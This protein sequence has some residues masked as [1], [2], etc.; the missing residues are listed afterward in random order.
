MTPLTFLQSHPFTV[1]VNGDDVHIYCKVKGGVTSVMYKRLIQ[2]PQNIK[3]CLEGPYG[4]KYPYDK[5]DSALLFA[6]GNGIPGLY[7]SAMDISK[8]EKTNV[9]LYWIIR[10]WKSIN[11]FLEELQRLKGMKVKVVI[12]VSSPESLLEEVTV[13]TSS[14]EDL[15]EKKDSSAANVKD[16]LS[17]VE[18]REGRPDVFKVL[19]QD[20]EESTG[21]VSVGAC[22]HPAMCDDVR[23]AVSDLLG[24]AKGK[25]DYFE[26]LLVW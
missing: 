6:G 22:G 23:K 10:E 26:E 3:V 2:G 4:Q 18:F 15:T 20:I 1:N 17:F 25:V 8:R 12:Y 14:D 24:K 9:K 21:S 19:A 11:W 5:Y 16:L 7:D 13:A